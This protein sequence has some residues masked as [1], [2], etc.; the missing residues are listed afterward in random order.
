MPD[1]RPSP[2]HA[3]HQAPPKSLARALGEFV[4][5]IARAVRHD[6][7]PAHRTETLRRDVVEEARG[8]M[9]LRR[10]TIEEVEYRADD[11]PTQAPHGH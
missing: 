5:H 6:P 7:T 9:V 8:N 2:E 1:D 4:G 10:T 3:E 11:G